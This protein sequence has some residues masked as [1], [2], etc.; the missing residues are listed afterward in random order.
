MGHGFQVTDVIERNHF[1]FT[2]MMITYRF[3]HLPSNAA[4]S[5]DTYFNSHDKPP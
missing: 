5:V 1:Q 3:Q 2:W 4:K